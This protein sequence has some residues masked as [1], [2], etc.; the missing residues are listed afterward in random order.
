MMPVP[1]HLKDCVVPHSAEIDEQPLKAMVRCPCGGMIFQLLYPGQTHEYDGE[2]I[3]CT[4]QIGK[5]FFFLIKVKCAACGKEHL[6]LDADF[7]GWDGFVC[8]DPNQAALPRPDLVAWKCL[9]CGEE[10]HKA[11]ILIHAEGKDDFIEET[12][13]TFDEK[14]WPDG[15]GWFTMNIECTK[16]GKKTSEWVSYETM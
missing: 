11:D 3:P 2:I 7:H 9:E 1:T 4:A 13:G 12:G 15:F 5:K 10:A 14:R 6:L 8:H 16:C